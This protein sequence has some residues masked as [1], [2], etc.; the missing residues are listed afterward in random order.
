MR[1]MSAEEPAGR[2]KTCYTCE[3]FP[4]CCAW[5]AGAAQSTAKAGGRVTD[6]GAAGGVSNTSSSANG[7]ASPALLHAEA[8][9][10]R[11]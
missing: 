9:L 5:H 6:G 3:P 10:H 1:I 7:Q 4:K 2:C 8:V 11:W